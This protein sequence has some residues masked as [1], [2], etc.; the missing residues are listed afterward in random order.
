[1]PDA[2]DVH[3]TINK[4]GQYRFSCSVDPTKENCKMTNE[5]MHHIMTIDLDTQNKAN[6]LEKQQTSEDCR[7]DI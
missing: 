1:M 4:Q 7:S 6:N 3:R 5:K 2:R